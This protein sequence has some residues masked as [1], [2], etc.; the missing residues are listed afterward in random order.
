MSTNQ[1]DKKTTKPLVNY[2]RR[3]LL[4]LIKVIYRKTRTNIILDSETLEVFLLKLD[5]RK[6]CSL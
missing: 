5:Q 3:K 2:N 1:T 4:N 6:G